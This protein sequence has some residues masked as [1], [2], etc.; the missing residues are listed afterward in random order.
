MVPKP[1][2]E[3]PMPF[4]EPGRCHA[5]KRQRIRKVPQVAAFHSHDVRIGTLLL[6]KT[7]GEIVH[8]APS[9]FLSRSAFSLTAIPAA[10]TG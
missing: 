1:A 10:S 3:I 4:V 5:R 8:F 2:L 9:I 6:G 7:E